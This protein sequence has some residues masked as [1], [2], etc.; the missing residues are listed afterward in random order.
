VAVAVEVLP[1]AA[2]ASEA[3]ARIAV[4]LPGEGAVV[5]TGGTTAGSVY[6]HLARASAGWGDIDVFFSDERCVPPDHDKSNF[7]M[8]SALL[9]ERVGARRVHRMRGEDDPEAAAASYH[10]EIAP[11]VD[12]GLDLALLGLGRDCHIAALFPGS[13]ALHENVRL[14]AAVARPD[15]MRGLTLTPP[16]LL[17]AQRLILAVAGPSKADAVR[18]AVTGDEGADAC[19]ARLLT[20]HPDAT[21]LLDDAAAARL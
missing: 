4:A 15:G 1:S 5:I 12:T 8:A 20:Q 18:R 21:F 9:L 10:E 16:A 7:A 11:A 13:T 17:S 19:P 2:Y 6:G 14:C 3:A